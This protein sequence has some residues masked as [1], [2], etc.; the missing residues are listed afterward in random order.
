MR[1]IISLVSIFSI[2]VKLFSQQILIPVQLRQTFDINPATIGINENASF[3]AR[4]NFSAL[5]GAPQLYLF[6]MNRL[7]DDN[8][9]IGIQ[10]YSFEQGLNLNRGVKAAYSYRVYFNE[11]SFLSFG[12]NLDCFQA[13][14]RKSD[15]FVKHPSD[16][17]LTEQL[18]EQIAIDLDAGISFNTN[19]LY[20]DLAI[21]QIPGRPVAFLNDFATNTRIR[22]Y[23]ANIG[24]KINATEKFQI[25]P[26][27]IFTT[28]DNFIYRVDAGIKLLWDKSLW[29][30]SMYR[31]T[32]AIT[33]F[34]GYQINR[35]A[36]NI[37]WDHGLS[38]LYAYATG[39]WEI[40]ITYNLS[41]SLPKLD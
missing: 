34:G 35:L 18:E 7:A 2:V 24:F 9:G 16:P 6:S 32:E 33:I 26:N 14:F 19:A 25:I 15:Y 3:I 20:F 27:G 30:G 29:L 12:L 23:F 8:M 21:H 17:V 11:T 5:E 22:H 39:S 36:F 40:I 38:P 1:K 13:I 28:T 31:T 4:K 37:A 41:K 10:V